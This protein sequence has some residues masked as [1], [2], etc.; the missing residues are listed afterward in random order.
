[1]TK[2]KIN[3]E[4][5]SWPLEN[6]FRISRGSRT[7]TEVIQLTITENGKTGWAESVPYARYNET[8][9]SVT[10]Q[11]ESIAAQIENGIDNKQLNHLLP[12][13][14]ARNAV[15]CALWDLQAKRRN[16]P[17]DQILGLNP[18]TG[19]LTAQTLSIDTP[20]EMAKAASQINDYPLIKVKLDQSQVIERMTAVHRAAPDSQFIIDANEA[21]NISELELYVDKLNQMNVV[22]IEQPLAANRDDDL[23]NYNSPI[24]L[25]A[26]ESIHTSE[27]LEKVVQ[28]YQAINI[29][30]DKTGGLSE[31][32]KLLNQAQEQS[33]SIMIGCMVG[34]SLAMAP[35]T[36]LTGYADFVD[37]DAPT[38]LAKDRPFGM[39]YQAGQMSSVDQR[40]WGGP[41]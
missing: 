19:T 11:I 1:M 13:G 9:D 39:N 7:S 36:L 14:A 5:Q 38:L 31:A 17:V 33:L 4:H 37:L 25:C 41:V 15:D 16:R 27:D 29:K 24:P 3:V 23:I 34:T 6:E 12:A 8:L 20:D 21:W 2:R 35:A 22:L 40:L 30:L 10:Q 28:C 26:D 18:F 32:I